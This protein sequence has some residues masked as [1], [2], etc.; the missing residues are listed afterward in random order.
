MML[1]FK[2]WLSKESIFGQPVNEPA[3][4]P[5]HDSD[6]KKSN[7]AFPTYEVPAK[8][9]KMKKSNQSSSSSSSSS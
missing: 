2:E 8:S 5:E 6:C 3:P 7:Q 1:K 9:K 4:D